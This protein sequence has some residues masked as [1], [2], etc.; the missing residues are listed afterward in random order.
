MNVLRSGSLLLAAL[1]SACSA[2]IPEVDFCK[3]LTAAPEYQGRTFRTEIIVVPDYHG[4]FATISQCKARVIKFAKGSFSGSPTLRKLDD[5][6][7]RAY[8]TREGPPPLKAVAVHATALVEKVWFPA[9]GVSS[10]Q[11]GYVLRLLNAN[12]GRLV[13]IPAEILQ[14]PESDMARELEPSRGEKPR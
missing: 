12:S 7:E 6:V 10:L 2:Q 13:D 11:P 8:R 5:E 4:R 3:V 14:P 9:P 1:V